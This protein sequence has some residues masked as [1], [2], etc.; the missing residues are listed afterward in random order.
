[1]QCSRPSASRFT[2]RDGDSKTSAGLA[3]RARFSCSCCQ[4]RECTVGTWLRATVG[5]GGGGSTR[6]ARFDLAQPP[7]SSLPFPIRVPLPYPSSPP[8]TACPGLA[9]LTRLLRTPPPLSFPLRIPY[10]T[11]EC[12]GASCLLQREKPSLKGNAF[13]KGKSLLQREEA[14]AAKASHGTNVAPRRAPQ[15]R[16][17]RVQLVRRD[18]RDVSTLY[19]RE[20]GGGGGGAPD[21][22]APCVL[23]T[24]HEEA[25]LGVHHRPRGLGRECEMR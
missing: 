25:A 2:S 1:M 23:H 3:G 21:C 10:R 19:G 7:P 18:G 13:F 5:G 16:G 11:N 9:A 22:L 12:A 6:A 14:P 8:S 24:R 4:Q 15:G 17:W 20:G